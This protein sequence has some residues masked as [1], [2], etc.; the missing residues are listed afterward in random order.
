MFIALAGLAA[1]SLWPHPLAR[2][3]GVQ[4]AE[5]VVLVNSTSAGYGEWGA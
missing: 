3:Q 1:L 2:A 4:R 5:A